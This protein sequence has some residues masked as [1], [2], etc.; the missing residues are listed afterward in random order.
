[1]GGSERHVCMNGEKGERHRDTE[2]QTQRDGEI[3]EEQSRVE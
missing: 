3:P 1:M 2:T